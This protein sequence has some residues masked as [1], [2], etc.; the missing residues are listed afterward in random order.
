MLSRTA[1]ALVAERTGS[2]LLRDSAALMAGCAF[3][4]GNGGH[5]AHVL[6][7]ATC[8]PCWLTGGRNR[9]PLGAV[10]RDQPSHQARAFRLLYE[11]LEK[12]CTLQVGAR[13][14]DSLLDDGEVFIE[15]SD[16]SKL[17]GVRQQAGT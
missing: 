14:P 17:R 15:N 7:R 13:R 11:R 2:D 3:R 5:I 6:P 16:P 8:R 9:E 4:R 1:L 12:R 10:P